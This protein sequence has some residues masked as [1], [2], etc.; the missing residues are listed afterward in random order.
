[1]KDVKKESS[2][3]TTISI[4]NNNST[5]TTTLEIKS[6]KKEKTWDSEVKKSKNKEHKSED[7]KSSKESSMSSN[8]SSNK[9]N[10]KVKLKDEL[11]S[12]SSS[13]GGGDKSS[14]SNSNNSGGG[15]GGKFLKVPKEKIH[16]PVSQREVSCSPASIL[17]GSLTP[18]GGGHYSLGA[19]GPYGPSSSVHHVPYAS[20]MGDMEQPLSPMSSPVSSPGSL[21]FDSRT[22][23]LLHHHR[24]HQTS[25]RD[26]PLS[27][28][29]S[30]SE[31]HGVRDPCSSETRLVQSSHFS[32]DH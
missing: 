30:D 20:M 5:G 21:H 25:K 13:A 19:G 29:D 7:I 6:V 28:D 9:N 2:T 4:S 18:G 27:D 8:S 24:S 22:H 12:K 32:S 14:S 17:S 26:T 1:M 16:T 31:D 11:K 15:G 23:E 3:S 10:S